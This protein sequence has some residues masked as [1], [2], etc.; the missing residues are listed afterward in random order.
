MKNPV[1]PSPTE[2]EAE[3]HVKDSAWPQGECLVN[4]LAFLLFVCFRIII[5]IIIII[6]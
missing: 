4:Q 3:K 2:A 1:L 5:I 6:T